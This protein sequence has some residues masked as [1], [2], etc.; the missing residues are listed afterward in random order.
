[1]AAQLHKPRLSDDFA[2]VAARDRRAQVV[3]DALARNAAQ[4]RN[5][6]TWPSK[7][8]STVISKLKCAVEAPE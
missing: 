5:A 3:I 4:P 7:N 2:P 1:M 8:D 6:R